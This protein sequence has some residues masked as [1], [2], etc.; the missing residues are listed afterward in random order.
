MR[1]AV[2]GTRYAVR[3]MRH[4]VLGTRKKKQD[5][6]HRIQENSLLLCSPK[7]LCEGEGEGLPFIH[8]FQG[9]S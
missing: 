4:G 9:N 1:Y 5:T 3:G 2:C 8:F 7:H 6:R